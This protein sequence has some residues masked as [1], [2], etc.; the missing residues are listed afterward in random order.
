MGWAQHST[1]GDRDIRHFFPAKLKDLLPAQEWGVPICGK[2]DTARSENTVD[3][4]REDLTQQPSTVHMLGARLSTQDS[5]PVSSH[6]P[7]YE[8]ERKQGQGHRGG[9]KN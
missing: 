3:G 8:E 9:N 4:I 2:A 1:R 6:D 7:P 5:S